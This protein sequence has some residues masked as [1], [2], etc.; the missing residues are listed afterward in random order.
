MNLLL[1]SSDVRRQ[2]AK[3]VLTALAAP[4]GAV[5]RFRYRPE[6]VPPEV[7]EAISSGAVVGA[8]TMVCFVSGLVTKQPFM[9]PVRLATVVQ[10]HLRGGTYVF[11]LRAGG[12]VDLRHRAEQLAN[13][14]V[15]SKKL[16][17]DPHRRRR[18]A[19]HV[20]PR[21]PP[22]VDAVA[23]DGA[24]DAWDETARRLA[25]HPTYA[26]TY[27]LKLEL[28]PTRPDQ[29]VG[30]GP[31]GQLEVVDGQSFQLVATV[32]AQNYT[33][34]DRWKVECTTGGS[35]LRVVSPDTH[36]IELKHDS[37]EFWLESSAAR[38]K[39]LSLA[40]LQ[41][42]R[43]DGD[44]DSLDTLLGIPVLVRPSRRR[45]AGR[46]LVTSI[47]ALLVALPAVLGDSSPVWLSVCLALAGASLLATASILLGDGSQR[48]S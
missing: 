48:G 7:R 43:A 14:I 3:D 37:V 9:L 25:Q 6:H 21:L 39:A 38:G 36:G 23:A 30:F 11:N 20:V 2:Y 42:A 34:T 12:Y 33:P 24:W 27:F 1:F 28:T 47:G 5:L 16:L 18:A 41:L 10:A 29:P 8:D 40:T 4:P 13:L 15:E 46:I 32:Y 44:V 17:A 26:D 35:H 19:V 45:L 31:G 22:A